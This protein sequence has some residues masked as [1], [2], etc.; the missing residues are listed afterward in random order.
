MPKFEDKF[1]HFTWDDELR[2]KKCF[3]ADDMDELQRL[4]NEGERETVETCYITAFPFETA[5]SCYKF[6]YYDSNYECKIAYEQGKTIQFKSLADGTWQDCGSKEDLWR[7]NYEYRIEPEIE[8]LAY[9]ILS[10]HE[11]EA[12]LFSMLNGGNESRHVYF[13]GTPGECLDYIKSHNKFAPIM[14]AW[15]EGKKI[16]FESKD[17]NTWLSASSPTWNKDLQYRARPEEDEDEK[18]SDKKALKWTDLNVGDIIENS[19]QEHRKAMVIDIDFDVEDSSCHI[20]AGSRWVSDTDL[21]NW[22]KVDA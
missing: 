15:E 11:G 1:V 12:S 16:E 6:A 20:R 21:K 8:P 14:K 13:I 17:T 7:D 3:L 9:V 2:G 18:V 19:T 22:R 10:Q 4:F 5:T